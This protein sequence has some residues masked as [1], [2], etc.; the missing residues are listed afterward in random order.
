MPKFIYILLILFLPMAQLLSAETKIK[1][2]TDKSE[3]N[4][5]D[6]I[7]IA[8]HINNNISEFFEPSFKPFIKLKGPDIVKTRDGVLYSFI[9]KATEPGEFQ[10]PSAYIV[11]NGKRKYSDKAKLSVVGST[12]LEN[13]QPQDYSIESQADRILNSYIFIRPITSKT[14]YY[15]GEEI[16]LSYYLYVH[17]D[18]ILTEI[19]EERAANFGNVMVEEEN[20]G[21]LYYEEE[22]IGKVKYRKALI[23]KYTLTSMNEGMLSIP[24]MSLKINA[25][26]EYTDAFNQI[27]QYYKKTKTYSSENKNIDIIATP[28][29]PENFSGAVGNFSLK[30][31]SEK[32]SAKPD[33][34]IKIIIELLGKG[35]FYLTQLPNLILPES[36]ISLGEPEIIDSLVNKD[37]T[38]GSRLFIYEVS[39]SQT[40]RYKLNPIS[41]N[42]FSPEQGRFVNAKSNS[43]QIIITNIDNNEELSIDS[44]LTDNSNA[45][46]YFSY[47]S[48]G[49]I[50]LLILIYLFKRKKIVSEKTAE[51]ATFKVNEN[52]SN[53]NDDSKLDILYFS[54]IKY[55]TD[56]FDIDD[57]N[58]SPANISEKLRE[59]YISESTID[60]LLQI[61]GKLRQ[62]RF[63]N[64]SQIFDISLIQN[65][66]KD[67][68]L[69][70][71]SELK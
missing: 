19:I 20:I 23:R 70:I 13:S 36:M 38:S 63:S 40:G 5:N 7:N 33:E 27:E 18:I 44:I 55:L 25:S 65:K 4:V 59:K 26:L 42:Y 46:E 39:A 56:T 41:L 66:V 17:S 61:F 2:L 16:V 21:K 30:L 22:Q 58:I 48:A 11:E 12:V 51:P 45:I 31:Y 69:K 10:I 62:Y 8:Y 3:V 52:F 32:H 53:L 64:N 6:R 35:S 29:K 60:E 15:L 37:G 67:I 68:I 49:L 14:Q 43:I 71:N 9:I 54:L 57:K 47:I 1:V 24:R 28:P 50:A 34:P